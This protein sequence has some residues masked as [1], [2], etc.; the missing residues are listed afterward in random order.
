[1]EELSEYD[2]DIASSPKAPFR[3]EL[4]MM[5]AVP[6]DASLYSEF[7]KGGDPPTEWELLFNS[8]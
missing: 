1:M 6:M 5:I 7:D 4:D 2:E 3:S 8:H